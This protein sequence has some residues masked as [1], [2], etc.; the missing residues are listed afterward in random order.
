MEPNIYKSTRWIQISLYLRGGLFQ[1]LTSLSPHC[2]LSPVLEHMLLG[3]SHA[4]VLLTACC[5]SAVLVAE[6]NNTSHTSLLVERLYHLVYINSVE[7]VYILPTLGLTVFGKPSKH[8][9]HQPNKHPWHQP[10]KH[11]W[12]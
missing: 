5:R 6:P 3:V 9:W 11:R 10:S 8:R 4:A 12:P 7:I 2:T 1:M